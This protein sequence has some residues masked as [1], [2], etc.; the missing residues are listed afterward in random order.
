VR[1]VNPPEV[2]GGIVLVVAIVGVIFNLFA[3]AVLAG[4]GEGKRSLNVEGASQRP[5][6]PLRLHRHRAFGPD[7]AHQ[8]LRP[9]RPDRVLVVAALMLARDLAAGKS[10]RVFLEAAR[11]TSTRRHR[12]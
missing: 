6:R 7:R 11:R 2:E 9:R 1:L 5:Q 4:G 10:G 12:P 8:R 3:S